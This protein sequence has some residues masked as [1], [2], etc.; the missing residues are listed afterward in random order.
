MPE[1]ATRLPRARK[2]ITPEWAQVLR[3]FYAKSFDTGSEESFIESVEAFVSLSPDEQAF[4][5]A[6][7][8]YRQVQALGDVHACL[9]R[10]EAGLPA[11]DPKALAALRHLPGIRK[12]LVVIAKGQE[13]ML[14]ALE[15]GAGRGGGDEEGDEGDDDEDDGGDDDEDSELADA[16]DADEIEEEDHGVGAVEV[17]TPEVLPAGARRPA[18][19]DGEGA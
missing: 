15:A 9:R 4:H 14:E 10:I 6:H 19:D 13:E 3:T 8:T 1:T 7:L 18:A 11:L 5:Q 12:A 2:E 16:V 17:L